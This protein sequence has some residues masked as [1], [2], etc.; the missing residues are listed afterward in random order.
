MTYRNTRRYQSI[1]MAEIEVKKNKKFDV[2]RKFIRQLC[3][4]YVTLVSHV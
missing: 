1:K 4:N 2:Q 3:A